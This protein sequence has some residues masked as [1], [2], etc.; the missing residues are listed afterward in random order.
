[1]LYEVITLSSTSLIKAK[2]SVI[3]SFLLTSPRIGTKTSSFTSKD[4]VQRNKHYWIKILVMA[5]RYIKGEKY[6]GI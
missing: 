4:F 1:M 5:E 2:R 6:L 3:I